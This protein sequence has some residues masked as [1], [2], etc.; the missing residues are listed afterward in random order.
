MWE[1]R[2]E[3]EKYSIE[4]AVE[5]GREFPEWFINEPE[6]FPGDEFYLDAFGDLTTERQIGFSLGQIPHSKIKQYG[7]DFG[8][9]ATTLDFFIRIIRSIDDKYL[10]WEN[11][12]N[13]KRQNL[14]NNM[15]DS[16]GKRK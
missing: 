11:D 13:K 9:D 10:G 8:L 6:T 7:I 2:F 14:Q 15:S 3:K 16:K 5:K 1:L 12:E 4:A